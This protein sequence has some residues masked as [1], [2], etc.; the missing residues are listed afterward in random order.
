MHCKLTPQ[1]PVK[2]LNGEWGGGDIINGANQFAPVNPV[3]IASL[4]TNN[5]KRRQF[6]GGLNINLTPIKGLLVRGSF[7]TDINYQNQLYFN[8]AY[9]IGWAVNPS[10]TLDN[11]IGQ[12]VLLE[13]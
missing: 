7:N 5:L 8:P 6:L 10:A 3:A 2:N 13:F 4:R 12:G 1:V 9:K 11:F